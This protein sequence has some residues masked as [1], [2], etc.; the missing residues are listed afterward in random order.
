LHSLKKKYGT[1]LGEKLELI[2]ADLNE[3]T[4]PTSDLLICNLVIEYIGIDSFAK[5]LAR[6]TFG[7]ASCVIQKNCGNSFMTPT[8]V[9]EKLKRI[10]EIHHDIGE[11]EFKKAIGL[12]VVFTH[13]Y[14]LPNNKEFV[15]IDFKR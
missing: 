15:R 8:K 10:D 2:H 11:N 7:I 6:S 12:N 9:A 5:L 1:S 13:N 4:L 3:T 14:L